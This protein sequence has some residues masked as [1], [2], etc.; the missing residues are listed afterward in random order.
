MGFKKRNRGVAFDAASSSGMAFL[1]SQLELANPTLVQPLASVSHKR[2][3]TVKFGGGF[4]E[5]LSAYQADYA[6]TGGNQFGLQGT[7]NTDIPEIQVS[8]GKGIWKAWNWAAS[9][10]VT[11]IDVKRLEAAKRLGQPAPFSLNQLLDTGTKLVWN[12]MM[13]FVVYLGWLGQPGLVNNPSVTAA[14][15]AAG[16]SG[17]TLWSQKTPVEILNDINNGLLQTVTASGF[18]TT[19]MANRL[20]VGW[21]KW[22]ILN[23]PMTIGGFSSLLEYVL[24]N[25]IGYRTGVDFKI[26]PLPNPYIDGQ[27]AGATDRGVYYN[28]SEEDVYIQVPQPINKAFTLPTARNG[29]S[30]ETIYNGCVGQV[31]WLRTQTAFYQ[32]GI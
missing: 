4:V 5:F 20:L 31:Q 17:S 14:L 19:G 3:I 2:D 22:T 8:V 28:D 12:K 10:V 6:S 26:F 30:Y 21:D 25:N 1:S 11:Y 16:A 27:G 23:Q 24:K 18:D 32:D 7:S 13:D 29:G 15:A 9:L